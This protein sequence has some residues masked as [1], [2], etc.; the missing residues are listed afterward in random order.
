MIR[1]VTLRGLHIMP[2][3]I[4]AETYRPMARDTVRQAEGQG[5]EG[6]PLG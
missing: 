3:G 5:L 1:G 6:R 2:G 4:Q